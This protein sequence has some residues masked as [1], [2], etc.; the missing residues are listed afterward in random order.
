MSKL[1]WVATT[2]INKEKLK[3]K[4]KKI[5]TKTPSMKNKINQLG[6]GDPNLGQCFGSLHP[7]SVKALSGS[8]PELRKMIP[9]GKALSYDVEILPKRGKTHRTRKSPT[10]TELKSTLSP[11]F[12][13]LAD[14][15]KNH[16]VI[17]GYGGQSKKTS[18]P[19]LVIWFLLWLNQKGIQSIK[20]VK[21]KTIVDYY[22]HLLEIPNKRKPGGLSS[23]YIGHHLF[24]LK[25]LFDYLVNTNIINSSPVSLPKFIITR[26]NPREIA[27]LEEIKQMYK[28][29]ETYRDR[30]ILSLGY[31]CAMR[32]REI[33]QFKIN[34]VK[35][36]QG[37]LFV[38]M[39]KNYKNRIIPFVD[40]VKNDLQKYL[41]D[42]RYKYC[43]HNTQE[44]IGSFLINN[45]GRAMQ[46][47]D[48]NERLKYLIN[49]TGN[50]ELIGKNIT[51]HCLRHSL[52]TH[53]LDAGAEIE[54][55]SKLLG[56]ATL[57]TIEIYSRRRKSR[58][59]AITLYKK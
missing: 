53:L 46:G 19:N 38:V 48:M 41:I 35:I 50:K 18:M 44:Y 17:V 4:T 56:H 9:G 8:D 43:N 52:A 45:H 28:A 54:F 49:K 7:T 34:H 40:Y 3:M 25:V 27:T 15:Y 22:E 57:D 39:G 16:I 14:E 20:K 36:N 59:R 10:T 37:F 32:R 21:A 6:A 33:E 51:M 5:T 1:A 26:A 2:H 29:C 42:E 47:E 58:N 23:S 11:A 30:C 12:R 13:A 31:G 55:V 24:S